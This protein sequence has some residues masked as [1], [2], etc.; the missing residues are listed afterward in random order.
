MQ[1]IEAVDDHTVKITLSEPNAA[2]LSGLGAF[3]GPKI[4]PKHLYEGTDWTTN[5]NND[6]PVGC[7]PFMFEEWERG[8]FI[9]VVA[10]PDYYRGRPMLDRIVTRFYPIEGLISA[11]ESGEIKYSYENFPFTEVSRLQQDERYCVEPNA[12]P[13]VYW[14]GFNMTREPFDDVRVRQAIALAV[15]RED[16]SERVFLGYFVP[17]FGT[18]PKG[19]AYNPDAEIE[20]N[21]EQAMALLDE[22]GLTPDADGVRL[23]ATITVAS[24]MSFPDVVTVMQEQLR[25]IGVELEIETMDFA[26]YTAKV[27]ENRDFDIAGGGG[28]AGPD[29]NEFAPFVTSDGYR[30][31]MG[32]ANARVDELF[33]AGRQ[34]ANQDERAAF[35]QEIQGILIED[36][37]RVVVLDSVSAFPH[38]CEVENPYFA[39]E[40]IGK[41]GN[42]D[43]SFLYTYLAEEQ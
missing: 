7:G 14:F 13:L 30:N 12:V 19:W 42:Q 23:R 27:T 37:P 17:N 15:N 43:Y 29:P 22:A 6:T 16:I 41:P 26:A 35:Y 31:I 10:N 5:E 3:Y 11:F 39:E 38:W 33:D 18:A 8:S 32:Y 4:M 34:T 40:L 9:S 28:L 20:Y 1:S 24:V 36:M 2:F 21:L 25:Q